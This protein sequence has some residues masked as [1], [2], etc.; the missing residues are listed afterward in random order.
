MILLLAGIVAAH[1]QSLRLDPAVVDFGRRPENGEFTAVV[2]V[3]NTGPR[4]VRVDG[5]AADCGC[6]SVNPQGLDLKAGASASVTVRIQSGGLEGDYE[7]HVLF[8]VAGAP[9]SLP[10]RISVYLFANWG[11]RPGRLILPAA[12][13]DRESSAMLEVR[14]LGGGP[15]PVVVAVSGSDAVKVSRPAESAGRLSYRVTR[16]RGAAPGPVYTSIRIVTRDP[17][18]PL[19]EVPVFA[20]V[21]ER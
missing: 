7:H 20:Y 9:A 18:A 19:L 17:K 11:L 3:A 12:G 1:G 4:P 13:G 21:T 6:L 10:V 16:V 15:P 5:I 14:W 8:P 2:T